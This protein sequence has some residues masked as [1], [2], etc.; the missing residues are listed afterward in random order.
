MSNGEAR[1][2]PQRILAWHEMALDRLGGTELATVYCT[3][4][5]TVIPYKAEVGGVHRTFGARQ[6]WWTVP[7]RAGASL[8]K[9]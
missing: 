7:A 6:R 8:K 5:G 2:Y 4:C 9:P 3:L 1:A